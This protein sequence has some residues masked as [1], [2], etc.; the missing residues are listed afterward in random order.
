[1]VVGQTAVFNHDPVRLFRLEPLR[2]AT[3]LTNY[4]QELCFPEV[5]QYCIEHSLIHIP[6]DTTPD[7]KQLFQENAVT[8]SNKYHNQRS[9]LE[10]WVVVVQDLKWVCDKNNYVI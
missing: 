1:M 10:L 6:A 3:V 7:P 5:Y 8:A 9:K 4:F 2:L